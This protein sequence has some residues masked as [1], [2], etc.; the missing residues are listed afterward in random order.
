MVAGLVCHL[1]LCFC[2]VIYREMLD[3]I[4]IFDGKTFSKIKLTALYSKR[5]ILLFF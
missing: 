5:A 4:E 3:G 2:L 1:L